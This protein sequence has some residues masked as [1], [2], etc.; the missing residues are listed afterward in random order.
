MADVH[1]QSIVK[2]VATQ[3]GFNQ[4]DVRL[5]IDTL[6]NVIKEHIMNCRFVKLKWAY[7]LIEYNKGWT[8][9]KKPIFK[10]G[11]VFEHEFS[12]RN[13]SNKLV[14]IKEKENG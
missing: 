12:Q 6:L 5:V 3:T 9:T 2:E 1:F 10:Y 7:F 13:P 11:K 4:T 14:R 8:T